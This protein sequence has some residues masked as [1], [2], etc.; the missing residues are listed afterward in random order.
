MLKPKRASMTKVRYR[1]NG[2]SSSDESSSTATMVAMPCVSGEPNQSVAQAGDEL[3][4]AA[5]R[6]GQQQRGIEQDAEHGETGLGGSVIRRLLVG[7]ERDFFA[8]RLRHR[9]AMR[10]D[11]GQM[12]PRQPQFGKRGQQPVRRQK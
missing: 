7:G 4:A 3:D 12:A 1:L 8:E 11:I 5:Q 6:E 9:G 2:A 10:G